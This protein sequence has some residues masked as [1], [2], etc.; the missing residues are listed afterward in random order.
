MAEPQLSDQGPNDAYIRLYDQARVSD[1]T[2]LA[3]RRML[4]DRHPSAALYCVA[5]G[6]L[7][8]PFIP[9]DK[10]KSPFDA[11]WEA[12]KDARGHYHFARILLSRV[13]I[14]SSSP[15][16]PELSKALSILAQAQVSMEESAQDPQC[17]S[18]I[19]DLIPDLENTYAGLL[20]AILRNV[21]AAKSDTGYPVKELLELQA[22]PH[23][24]PHRRLEA[25]FPQARLWNDNLMTIE[26]AERMNGKC[27]V[28]KDFK[29]LQTEV[30]RLATPV[31]T[32]GGSSTE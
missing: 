29:P 30:M 28:V 22:L 3:G 15:R 18:L 14:L 7:H 25:L 13:G 1:F 8:K 27:K 32:T 6:I 4:Q 16:L 10:N 9:G 11:V 26:I 12:G 31:S 21:Q 2:I 17:R 5:C 24:T 19:A 20:A 23:L